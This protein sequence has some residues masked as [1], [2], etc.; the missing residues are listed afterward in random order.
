M[1]TSILLITLFVSYITINLIMH[2]RVIL[3]ISLIGSDNNAKKAV[4]TRDLRD[5]EYIICRWTRVS[6]YNYRLIRDENGERTNSFCRVTGVELEE[7]L[8]YELLI[9]DNS[10][11]FYVVEKNNTM[12][13][14]LENK[15]QS[16]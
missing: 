6:G 5:M 10:F 15:L 8:S 9:S 14:Y 13:Q 12:T 3:P 4:R 2:Q 7:E 11:V 16:I 1:I